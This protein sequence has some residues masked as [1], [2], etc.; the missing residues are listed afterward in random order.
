VEQAKFVAEK[1]E[2]EIAHNE[3]KRRLRAE[4]KKLSDEEAKAIAAE[5]VKNGKK[6][7]LANLL[8]QLDAQILKVNDI[9]FYSYDGDTKK[10]ACQDTDVLI[11]KI[12]DILDTVLDD[13][14]AAAR[15]RGVRASHISFGANVPDIHAEMHREWLSLLS[16]LENH[17]Q[18]LVECG[19]T[20]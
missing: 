16:Y 2:M 18:N 19:K 6:R 7:L 10:K 11:E 20:T 15:F 12:A 17:K 13:P 1:T 14:F 5:R 3:E 8:S 9:S 4:I